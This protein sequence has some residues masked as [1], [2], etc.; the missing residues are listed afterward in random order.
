MKTTRS[1]NRCIT[2]LVLPFLLTVGSSRLLAQ[3]T[4]NAKSAAQLAPIPAR[5]TQAIDE[6][7]LTALKGSVHPLARPEFDRGPVPDSTPMNRML[8][9]LQRSPQ[10]E[11]ALQQLMA[12]QMSKASP[13]FH[14]WLTPAQFGAQFGPADGDLQTVTNWL[15]SQGFHDIKVGTGKLTIEF[16]GNVGL[17]RH[18]FHTD[19]HHF[20]VNG[21]M[22]QANV[23]DPEIPAALTPV[24][25]GIVS[26]HNFPKKS[27]IHR[28][29][30]FNGTRD[31]HGTPQ[32][33]TTSGCGSGGT[34]PCYALGPADFAAIYD[35]PAALTGSGSKIAI[36]GT[37]DI[38][39][40]D[41]SSF[42]TLF[43]LPNNPP[44]VVHNGPA[45]GIAAEEGEADLD[46][47]WS[48]AV[49]PQAEIDFTV[50][51]DT[52][53]SGGIEL[54]SL[55]VIDNNTDDIMSL[56]FGSCETALGSENAFLNALWEQ[57]AAQ[58]IT[59]FVSAGD[60]GSAGCDDFNTATVAMQGLAVNGL[61]STPFNIAVGGTDF[62]DV[63]TQTT[64]WNSTNAAGTQQSVK[65]YIPETTWN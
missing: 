52:L 16:S 41:V 31:S 19:I 59:V 12:D 27:M 44:M 10:Q 60:P 11:A 23:S 50:T 54:S 55:Y 8:L 4:S 48:G 40:N 25:A 5:I 64:F 28:A 43:G 2:L 17:V 62:D 34:Q 6:T 46:V 30:A 7:Q 37:S 36:I 63:G 20:V 13:N 22:R 14:N 51:E 57:A 26:L 45:P 58:G 33:T 15:S 38:D 9:F 49:A 1:L 18:T 42:R 21:E 39:P 61:A 56:S 53:T 24:V 35:I 29:G 32:L 3:T 65:G 47:E